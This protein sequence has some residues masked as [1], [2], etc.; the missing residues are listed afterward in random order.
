MLGLQ[1]QRGA[2]FKLS[3][4]AHAPDGNVFTG[5]EFSVA[6]IERL[7]VAFLAHG[8]EDMAERI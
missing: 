8:V 1:I 3:A 5:A 7:L 4:Q 6:D 2:V